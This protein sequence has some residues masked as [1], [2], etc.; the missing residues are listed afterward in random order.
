MEVIGYHYTNAQ[1][2][3]PQRTFITRLFGIIRRL[4]YMFNKDVGV[5][6]L[7]GETLMVLAR[8]KY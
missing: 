7:G 2:S 5:R 4:V 6:M 3:A 1:T 8:F